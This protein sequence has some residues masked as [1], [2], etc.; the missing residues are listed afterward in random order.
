MTPINIKDIKKGQVILE[1]DSLGYAITRAVEDAQRVD[2][3]A[4]HGYE[5]K[6][7]VLKITSR[8]GADLDSPDDITY[9]TADDAGHYASEFH[10]LSENDENYLLN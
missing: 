7:R 8:F 4:Y 10:L 2:R 1:Q 3:D 5:F 9:F 6:G